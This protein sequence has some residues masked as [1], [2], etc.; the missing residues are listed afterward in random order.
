MIK[1][2]KSLLQAATE[3]SIMLE[4]RLKQT[5]NKIGQTKFSKHT[6]DDAHIKKVL[7]KVSSETGLKVEE[8]QAGI[9]EEK[10]KFQDM[11][12]KAPMLYGTIMDNIIESETFNLLEKHNLSRFSEGA[13]EFDQEVFDDLVKDIKVEFPR[14]WPMENLDGKILDN[15][16]WIIIP[17]P[18]KKNEKFNNIPTAAATPSGEFI[19]NSNFCQRLIDFAH[20]KKVKPKSKFFKCRG[21]DIPDDYSYIEF[22]IIHEVMHYTMSDWHYQKKFNETPEV[23]NWVGD[24][25]TNYLLAKSGF[26]QLPV[27]LFSD[28]INYDR[29]DM[30]GM[31]EAVRSE[32]N[33]LT[34]DQ[35]K[36]VEDAIGKIT[37][38]HPPGPDD[39]GDDGDGPPGEGRGGD[40][41]PGEGK[42]KG[43]GKGKGGY[44]PTEEELEKQVQDTIDK[45]SKGKQKLSAEEEKSKQ[46]K[47]R[48]GS[49]GTE[50]R[51]GASSNQGD[52]VKE[53][54]PNFTWGQILTKLV[55][56]STSQ[57]EETY[58]KINRR[59]VTGVH[60]A[61]AHGAGAVTPGEIQN[62][63]MLRLA[64]VIDTSGSMQGTIGR[65]FANIKQLL[66]GHSKSLYPEFY[67]V[68]FSD[69]SH[70]FKCNLKNRTAEEVQDT[71]KKGKGT[72][73]PFEDVV[74]ISSGG[75]TVFGHELATK[76]NNLVTNKFNVLVISDSDIIGDTWRDLT[77]KHKNRVYSLFN[78]KSDF[79]AAVKCLGVNTKSISHMTS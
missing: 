13:S 35:Q 20:I 75:G 6:F 47:A 5:K 64:I 55:R 43:K 65:V 77:L 38:E 56:D 34:K 78:S 21:G 63:D 32:F 53:E 71:N 18:Y 44:V 67:V 23:S 42:G 68:K 60:A 3:E 11:R 39:D 40:G 16:Q 52:R 59:G 15:D 49:A 79:L 74:S 72:K 1:I 30:R 8:L 61:N 4:A 12:D 37:D 41:P 19:F 27:G 45:L 7:E 22:L 46:G 24:F 10:T 33:K 25:R 2:L 69:S 76:I 36:K 31:Y 62:E 51:K 9:N 73:V 57:P 26:D 17:S 29:M 28:Q 58:Q 50:E 70:M 14:F 54:S 66:S 48:L